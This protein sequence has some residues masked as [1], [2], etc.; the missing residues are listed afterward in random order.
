MCEPHHSIVQWDDTTDDDEHSSGGGDD[1]NSPRPP[2]TP[3]GGGLSATDK[4]S[5]VRAVFGGTARWL[6]KLGGFLNLSKFGAGHHSVSNRVTSVFGKDISQVGNPIL[7]ETQWWNLGVPKVDG[8]F[9]L[10]GVAGYSFLLDYYGGDEI[11]AVSDTPR[12]WGVVAPEPPAAILQMAK[13]YH[14]DGLKSATRYDQIRTTE[15]MSVFR[16]FLEESLQQTQRPGVYVS[17]VL[18]DV[19]NATGRDAWFAKVRRIAS[20]AFLRHLDT[21]KSGFWGTDQEQQ[22][23]E[24]KSQLIA[25]TIGCMRNRA[26][27]KSHF[28][29][30][31]RFWV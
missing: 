27:L 24:K 14:L 18:H 10:P 13:E 7:Y 20:P 26:L 3:P 2:T 1:G 16:R 22:F 8:T 19:L 12:G 29:T 31:D 23:A 21:D 6:K 15:N 9:R 28:A 4:T 30:C 11:R 5:R 25:A 17:H